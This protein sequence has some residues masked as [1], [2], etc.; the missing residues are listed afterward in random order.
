M[1]PRVKS[2]I[3]G[4]AAP[5]ASTAW[6]VSRKRH[7]WRRLLQQRT[8]RYLRFV[9]R[10]GTT[11]LGR[12]RWATAE[13]KRILRL[14]TYVRVDRTTS[15]PILTTNPSDASL[16]QRG[17]GIDIMSRKAMVSGDTFTRETASNYPIRKSTT[18]AAY[19]LNHS[20][21]YMIPSKPT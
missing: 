20:H 6:S 21:G 12:F 16:G 8:L 17:T 9:K 13:V 2:K 18:C 15:Q 3:F 7:P 10:P 4:I 14:R 5:R 11:T 19:L 1:E